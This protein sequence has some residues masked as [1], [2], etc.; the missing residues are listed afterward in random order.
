MKAYL[1]SLNEREKWMVIGAGI[2]LLGY[3]Y[4]LFFYEPLS[5]RVTQRTQQLIEKTET[6]EWMK[7]VSKNYHAAKPK[8]SLDNSKLLTVIS[9]KLKNNY[10]L[11]ASYELQQTSSGEIQLTF[12][13]VP[14]NLFIEWLAGLNQKYQL[15]IKQLE[16]SHAD[17]IGIVRLTVILS[18]S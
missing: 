6:L 9:S 10:T 16:A 2:C 18:A 14:F 1:N 8:Q 5:S 13:E 7:K 17:K 12:D 4:Y 15:T 11:N 3:L